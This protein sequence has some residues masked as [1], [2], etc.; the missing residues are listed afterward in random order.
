MILN[1]DIG[2]LVK[3]AELRPVSLSDA[4]VKEVAFSNRIYSAWDNEQVPRWVDDICF[5]SQSL[6]YVLARL[7]YW[8]KCGLR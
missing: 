1:M 3:F 2:I 8:L 5:V 6:M 7:N 4:R